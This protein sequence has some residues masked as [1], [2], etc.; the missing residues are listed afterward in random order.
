[1]RKLLIIFSVVCSSLS[2][3]Q[4]EWAPLET[5]IKEQLNVRHVS[6]DGQILGTLKYPP[7]LVLSVDMSASWKVIEDNDVLDVLSGIYLDRI[8][9][10]VAVDNAGDFYLGIDTSI[11]KINKANHELELFTEIEEERILE[12]M[13]LENGNFV[14]ANANHIYLFSSSGIQLQKQKIDALSVKFVSGVSDSLYLVFNVRDTFEIFSEIVPVPLDLQDTIPALGNNFIELGTNFQWADG[15]FFNNYGYSDDGKVWTKFP[16]DLEGLV[17]VLPDGRIHLTR[18]NEIYLSSDNGES[19]ELIANTVYNQLEFFNAYP[20]DDGTIWFAK[21][22]FCNASKETYA[23]I[24]FEEDLTTFEG[25][26]LDAGLPYAWYV[27]AATEDNVVIGSFCNNNQDFERDFTIIKNSSNQEWQ[28]IGFLTDF[29]C[30]HNR[31]TSMSDGTLLTDGGCYSADEGETWEKTLD[32]YNPYP[33]VSIKNDVAYAI[34][35][36]KTVLS[37]D[38]GRSWESVTFSVLSDFRLSN[39]LDISSSGHYFFHD[40]GNAIA[41]TTVRGEVVSEFEFEDRIL[42]FTTAYNGPEVYF[43]SMEPSTSGGTLLYYSYDDGESFTQLEIDNIPYSEEYAQRKF[44]TDHL[45]NVYLVRSNRIWMSSDKGLN[46]DEITPSGI[47]EFEIMDLEIGWDDHLYLALIGSPIL[48]SKLPVSDRIP[49]TVMIYDDVNNNC[50]FDANEQPIE[51]IVTSLNNGFVRVTNAAGE[52]TFQLNEGNYIVNTSH[53]TDLYQTCADEYELRIDQNLQGTTLHIPLQVIQNCADVNMGATTPFLRRCFPNTYYLELYN[54]GTSTA[55]DLEVRVKMDPYF[56][57]LDSDWDLINVI[58]DIY[59]FSLGELEAKKVSRGKIN[60]KLDCMVEL[61]EVHYLEAEISYGTP[62]L[63]HTEFSTNFECRTNIGSYD[64]NDKSI[65]VD[66]I[67]DAEIVGEDSALEYLIRFQNTGTDTAFTVRIEDRLSEEFDLL[68][69]RPMAASHDF[70]WELERRNL[71]VTFDDIDL[72][73]STRNEEAS[74]G[75]V[76][77]NVRLKDD[78]PDPGAILEN[79]AEIYF[80]FNDPIVTNTVESYYLCKHSNDNISVTICPEQEYEGY[81]IAGSYEDAFVT[82]LGCDSVRTLEL[83]VLDEA[84]PACITSNSEIDK[85]Y[86]HVYPV[87]TNAKLNVSYTGNGKISEYI[88]IDINGRSVL[89]NLASNSFLVDTGTL[90]SGVYVL[91]LL[92][93]NGKL[94]YRRFS[95]VN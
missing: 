10:N 83:I 7:S 76:K 14:V 58:E 16:N 8:N 25:D 31:I 1:M 84:D 15:R 20:L 9:M 3:A 67:A 63:D 75:F 27:E 40:F 45:G 81:T 71:I 51:R 88:M 72:V 34:N 60:F 18:K 30:L 80:D 23:N 17:T 24:Y 74:H 11:Y 53:R 22:A 42:G 32:N 91:S 6:G 94:I 50:E 4:I 87:P 70:R 36:D 12:F 38:F 89:R 68:S 21:G 59:T 48:R 90:K 85:S 69:I 52:A 46:W 95:I 92:L 47:S 93:E 54:E 19:F 43:L 64:P 57:Y 5:H 65:Y 66:G 39:R 86:L 49:L 55:T 82:S 78:R 79:T 35:N 41:K 13:F 29:Q 73:D 56:E 61:G 2:Y 62:C 37:E 28:Q 77:F 26:L 44:K 33:G